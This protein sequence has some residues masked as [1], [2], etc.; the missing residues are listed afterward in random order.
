MISLLLRLRSCELVTLEFLADGPVE[1]SV[2]READKMTS[3]QLGHARVLT[4]RGLAK[5][6]AGGNA[7]FYSL[8]AAGHGVAAL[9]RSGVYPTLRPSVPAPP[10]GCFS[11]NDVVAPPDRVAL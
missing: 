6:E 1:T 2:G 9:L 7:Y 8:T 10:A 5:F 11:P 4:Q 3:A